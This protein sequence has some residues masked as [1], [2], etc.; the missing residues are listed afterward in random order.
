MAT[1]KEIIDATIASIKAECGNDRAK[2]VQWYAEAAN[3]LA[4]RAQRLAEFDQQD[5]ASFVATK[6]QQFETHRAEQDALRAAEGI[7]EE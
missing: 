6:K 1:K 4:R 5:A 2:L 7:S 3:R